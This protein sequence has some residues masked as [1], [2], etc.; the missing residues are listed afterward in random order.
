MPL[1]PEQEARLKAWFNQE[2]K[3]VCAN[4]YHYYRVRVTSP[5]CLLEIGLC[6]C[7]DQEDMI[8]EVDKCPDWFREQE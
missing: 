2:P 8:R 1:S 6:R 3:H 7:R 5:S 4:C